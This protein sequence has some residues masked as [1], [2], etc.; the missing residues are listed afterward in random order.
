MYLGRIVEVAPTEQI[1]STPRHPYT[2]GL[3]AAIPR[4][5]EGAV[6]DSP[7]AIADDPPS[8]LRIPAG[9]RFRTRCPM[10]QARCETEDPALA[11][12][13]GDA[14]HLAACHFAFSTGPVGAGPVGAGPVDAGPVGA[15]PVGAGADGAG[16]VRSEDGRNA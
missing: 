9:C 15:G 11:A 7:P 12:A 4:M 3:L 16:A 2:R 10:A 14:E 8:P 1:F 13:P 6:D 5:T